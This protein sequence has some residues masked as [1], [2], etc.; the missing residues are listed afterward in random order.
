MPKDATIMNFT[1]N[2]NK[3][4]AVKSHIPLLKTRL[5][6]MEKVLNLQENPRLNE[7]RL[8]FKGTSKKGDLKYSTGSGEP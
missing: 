2:T 5:L 6:N 7:V 8:I 3:A 1:P 4:K